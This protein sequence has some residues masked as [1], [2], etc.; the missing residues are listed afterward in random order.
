MCRKKIIYGNYGTLMQ[1]MEKPV[2]N[3]LVVEVSV[4]IICLRLNQE[5]PSIKIREG[6]VIFFKT[7]SFN[8]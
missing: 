2:K 3:Q 8:D 1:S 7:K 6:T 4:C 5:G